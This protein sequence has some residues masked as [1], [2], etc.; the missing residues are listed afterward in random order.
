MRFIYLIL[1]NVSD[2]MMCSCVHILILSGGSLHGIHTHTLNL[3]VPGC[4]LLSGGQDLLQV[5]GSPSPVL[6]TIELFSLE[7]KVYS[8][9]APVK[10]VI[11]ISLTSGQW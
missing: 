4:P 2:H 8:I 5:L 3:Q 7:G 6:M 11:S 9:T 1:K 10:S